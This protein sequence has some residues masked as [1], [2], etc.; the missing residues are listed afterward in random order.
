MMFASSRRTANLDSSPESNGSPLLAIIDEKT[1]ALPLLKQKV[2]KQKDG[3]S[4]P[5]VKLEST[6]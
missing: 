4:G 3:M 5:A 1:L 6:L 2:A